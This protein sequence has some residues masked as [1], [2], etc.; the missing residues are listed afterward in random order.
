M[1]TA[2]DNKTTA[3]LIEKGL[4]DTGRLEIVPRI[5]ADEARVHGPIYTIFMSPLMNHDDIREHVIGNRTGFPDLNHAIHAQIAEGDTVVTYFTVS[6]TNT[7]VFVGQPPTNRHMGGPGIS[8]DTFDGSGRIVESWQTCDRTLNFTQLGA[9]P[10][11]LMPET[12]VAAED[13]RPPAEVGLFDDPSPAD[14]NRAVVRAL[15]DALSDGKIGT[16]DELLSDDFVGRMPGLPG[17]TKQD[18]LDWAEGV[19]AALWLEADVTRVVATGDWVAAQVTMSGVHR[20]E[21][22]GQPASGRPVT[23][24]SVDTWKV[25]DGR[26]VELYGLPD[27]FSLGLQTGAIRL[28]GA[29]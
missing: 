29:P 14:A 28:P 23:Y 5:F 27:N 16:L 20:A 22:L 21:H 17:P 18:F 6:G 12:H 26:V 10:P 15:Y 24:E 11:G 4:L 25:S 3:R 9:L 1:T 19:H 13:H 8:V 2:N 7:G